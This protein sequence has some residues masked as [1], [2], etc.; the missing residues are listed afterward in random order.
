MDQILKAATSTAKAM[1]TE[2]GMSEEL[3]PSKLW[4]KSRRGIFRKICC[5]KHN[6]VSEETSQKSRFRN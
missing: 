2:A 1:V 3:G 5:K 4:R 6:Q